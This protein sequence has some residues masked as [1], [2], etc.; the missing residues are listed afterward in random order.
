MNR[1]YTIRNELGSLI[2]QMTY[3]IKIIEKYNKYPKSKEY[4]IKKLEFLVNRYDNIIKAI[5][6]TNYTESPIQK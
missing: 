2:N 3:Q 4:N 1:Y 6:I 5:D